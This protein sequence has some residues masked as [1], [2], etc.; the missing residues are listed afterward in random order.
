MTHRN[1]FVDQRALAQA[2]SD[3]NGVLVVRGG[4][5][6]FGRLRR[7]ASPFAD[8]WCG[9][10]PNR[11]E[12]NRKRHVRSDGGV[13]LRIG[14]RGRRRIAQGRAT[15]TGENP[16]QDANKAIQIGVKVRERYVVC[17]PASQ[18]R[19]IVRQLMFPGH[20]GA[21]DED[22]DYPYVTLQRRANFN[23]A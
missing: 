11:C 14:F 4:A 23:V 15:R 20:R 17:V 9:D 18:R 7:Q 22:G 16:L 2:Q 8:E 6:Y 10:V 19:E 5:E 21:V 12:R 1:I 13:R 3:L